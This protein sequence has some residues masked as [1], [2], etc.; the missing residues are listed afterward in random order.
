M[1][2][3]LFLSDSVNRRYLEMYSDSGLHLP[4][5]DRLLKH[6]AVFDN[7]FV[8]SAPCMP[9]R[10]DILTGRLGFMDRNWGP[11]EAFDCTLPYMLR[12][13]GV[14]SHIVTDHYHYQ[15]I[16]GEGYL[17]MFDSWEMHHGQEI[18]HGVSRTRPLEIPEHYGK[19]T[20]QFWYNRQKYK[21]D[22]SAYPSPQTLQ[23]AADWLEEN[24]DSDNFLLWVE[25]FDPH[26][27][28]DVPQKY[29]DM[30]GDTYDDKLCLWPEYKHLSRSDLTEDAL[31][32]L[33]KRYMALLLMT[34]H[35]MG[36]LLD[37]M[38]RHSMWDDT[39][40]IYTTD[41]GYMLGEHDCMA[42]NYMPAYNECFH[43]PLLIH[44]PGDVGAGKRIQALT[45]NID[46][47]PTL[48]Q[49]YG[50][51]ESDCWNPLHGHSLLPLIQ[52]ETDS[53]RE[54]AIY[55]YFGKMMNIT[56]GRYTYFRAPVEGNMPLH[57]YTTL[58]T[59]IYHYFDR[60]RLRSIDRIEMG[61][62]LS[63]N[64]YPVYKIPGNNVIH[65]PT[66][67]LRFS[68]LNDWEMHDYLFDLQN[69][70]AQDHNIADERPDIVK[71]M[72]D[73]L[74]AAMR[75]HDAPDEQFIRLHLL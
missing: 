3:I 34:D 51:P 74:I 13:R 67:T 21:D 29:L 36:K 11:I 72:E 40:F 64:N 22:E 14:W 37:V 39:L 58:A 70:Y 54:C 33:R 35:W 20:P 60:D 71:E 50:V 18:D 57:V 38:D 73:K 63:W 1:R 25:P 75:A 10:R 8:G 68:F 30:V 44:L 15:E 24:H 52:G 4:N 62:F 23:S 19:I 31:I 55:G 49:Y 7:H 5:L 41:H 61:R 28:F 2:S 17:Q 56:D 69:D 45:Q 26:E 48:L 27:P 43:I 66:G 12:S 53:L 59:D 6:C 9:A 46:L 42:K 16:G 32:H 65:V 47:M